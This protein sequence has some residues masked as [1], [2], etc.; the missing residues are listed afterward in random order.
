MDNSN[1]VQGGLVVGRIS[2]VHGVRGW[3]KVLSYTEQPAMV[4]DYQPWY[5][6][7]DGSTQTVELSTWKRQGDS[8]VAHLKG[9]DDRDIARDW[10][11][12]DIRVAPGVFPKLS[13]TEFYWYQLEGLAV[14]NHFTRDVHRLG[15]VA[16][17]LETGANDVL[18]IEGDAESIDSRERL[19][20][21]SQAYLLKVDLET[22]RLD[23]VW[24]PDF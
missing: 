9:V 4:F 10:C 5:I 1:I 24:D 6:D 16:S 14:Y 3:V 17:L 11:H 7:K 21:Y 8:F 22:K 15:V 23:V 18:V 20:P 12:R 19:I 13:E 2:A